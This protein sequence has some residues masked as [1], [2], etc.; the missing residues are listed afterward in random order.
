MSVANVWPDPRRSTH[1]DRTGRGRGQRAGV[2][3]RARTQCLAW[4]G[5]VPRQQS[6]GGRNVLL[7]ITKR[8]DR[9]LR[10][11]L[12]HGA[13]AALRY[14]EQRSVYGAP[15]RAKHDSLL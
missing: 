3:E 14:A 15:T 13:R 7:G 10:M 9:Y 2:Q 4:L 6:S 11:L 1:R 12:I 8:G 5:L